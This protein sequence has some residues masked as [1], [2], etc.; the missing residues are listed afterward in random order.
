[1]AANLPAPNEMGLRSVTSLITNQGDLVLRVRAA[2]IC[3]T[4]IRICA[5]AR[6]QVTATIPSSVMIF[7]ARLLPPMALPRSKLASASA[8]AGDP[9]WPLRVMPARTR[10]YV[11]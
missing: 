3:G 10:R 1:M 7:R 9:G 2:T 5:R 11:S 8:L 6:R 4:N